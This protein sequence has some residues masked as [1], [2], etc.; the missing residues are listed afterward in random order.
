MKKCNICAINKPEREFYKNHATLD[1]YARRCKKCE[2][3]MKREQ[4]KRNPSTFKQK[5]RNYYLKNKGRILKKRLLWFKENKHKK[6]AHDA[7][8]NALYTG[9]II[10]LPCEICGEQRVDAHHDNYLKPLDVRWLCKTHHMRLHH[11]DVTS[12]HPH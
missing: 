6:R 5:D 1:G 8:K 7:V 11:E 10:R 4:R 12:R 3:L 2:S 9:K